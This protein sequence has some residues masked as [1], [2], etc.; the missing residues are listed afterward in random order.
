VDYNVVIVDFVQLVVDGCIEMS[1]TVVGVV[2]GPNIQNFV[3]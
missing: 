1:L 3:I 2:L